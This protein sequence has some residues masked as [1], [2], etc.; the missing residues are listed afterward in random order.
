MPAVNFDLVRR[1]LAIPARRMYTDENKPEQIDELLA[2]PD[3]AGAL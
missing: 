1:H 2:T 3:L